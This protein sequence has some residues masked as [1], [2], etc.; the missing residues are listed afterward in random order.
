MWRGL[1]LIQG[2]CQV[3][4]AVTVPVVSTVAIVKDCCLGRP[5]L[6][7]LARGV[8]WCQ[9]HVSVFADTAMPLPVQE[10]CP[11]KPGSLVDVI[12]TGCIA[13]LWCVVCQP[14]L[15][16]V[17]AEGVQESVGVYQPTSGPT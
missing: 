2:F 7:P 17:G 6:T 4:T 5:R 15:Y 14:S 9:Q 11:S 8:H 13:W 16:A 10:S 1:A 12:F 3:F